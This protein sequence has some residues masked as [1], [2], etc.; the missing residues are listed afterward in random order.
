MYLKVFRGMEYCEMLP[1]NVLLLNDQGFM[2]LFSF[3]FNILYVHIFLFQ[4]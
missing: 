4:I 1:K 3:R 2:C